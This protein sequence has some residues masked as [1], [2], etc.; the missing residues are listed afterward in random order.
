MKKFNLNELST[1]DLIKI[2]TGKAG[3][4]YTSSTMVAEYSASI[5]DE[6]LTS[7]TPTRKKMVLAVLELKNRSDALSNISERVQSSIDIN[8]LCHDI[9]NLDRETFKIVALN[10][11]CKVITSKIMFYG[12]Y[13][14]TTVDIRY[15]FKYLI[16]CKAVGFVI[17][18]NHPS[19][20]AHP[21][22]DDIKITNAIKQ[23]SEFMNIKLLDH[24]IVTK[25]NTYY[26]FSDEGI[27]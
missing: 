5:L 22:R 23:A 20:N 26:S 16:E 14:S 25:Y 3:K 13:T 11:A 10:A 17:A 6:V 2:I 21:S 4:E 1:D 12:G 18:H 19:G 15:V 8:K 7:L 27:L 24:V 9:A